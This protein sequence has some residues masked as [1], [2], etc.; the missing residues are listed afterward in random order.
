MIDFKNTTVGNIWWITKSVDDV[1]IH[2]GILESEML[3]QSGLATLETF[4]NETEWLQA[5]GEL[6]IN[7]EE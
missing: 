4:D 5:L 3:L 7:I 2:Y 6:N 1:I